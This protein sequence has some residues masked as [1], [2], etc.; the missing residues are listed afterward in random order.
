MG[1]CFRVLK[2]GRWLSLC[3]HDTSEGTWALIQDIMAEVGFVTDR[4]ESALFIETLSKS[5]NQ[6]TADKVNKRDLVINFRSHSQGGKTE[7]EYQ[8]RPELR[9]QP[10]HNE[11]FM[12]HWLTKENENKSGETPDLLFE[13]NYP[14]VGQASRL[15][16]GIFR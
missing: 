11:T 14:P 2:P 3:Y 6:Y 15:S 13:G 16:K 12:S 5:Y 10:E 4:T 9:L 8:R 1:E 7:S